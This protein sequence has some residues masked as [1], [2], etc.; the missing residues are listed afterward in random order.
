MPMP[1]GQI[2]GPARLTFRVDGGQPVV[3]RDIREVR[4]KIGDDG[5]LAMLTVRTLDVGGAREVAIG[6][7]ADVDALIVRDAYGQPIEP[8]AVHAYGRFRVVFNHPEFTAQEFAVQT[9]VLVPA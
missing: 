3:I 6:D 2:F 5:S 1:L 8:P 4:H 9:L 7:H